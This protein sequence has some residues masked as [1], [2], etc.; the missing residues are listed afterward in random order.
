MSFI[1]ASS[2]SIPASGQIACT[3][4]YWQPRSLSSRLLMSTLQQVY[5][6]MCGLYLFC[7]FLLVNTADL[8]C[9]TVAHTVSTLNNVPFTGTMIPTT[10]DVDATY[11]DFCS[12]LQNTKKQ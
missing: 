9:Q 2:F 12:Q 10:G 11:L 3:T 1:L 7:Q 6:T 5:H 8:C 4:L